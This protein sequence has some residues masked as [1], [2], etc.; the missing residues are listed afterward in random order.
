MRE[1]QREDAQKRAGGPH[2]TGCWSGDLGTGIPGC[3][4]YRE[5]CK[6]DKHFL[7][8]HLPWNSNQDADFHK[9]PY[10]EGHQL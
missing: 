10:R 3:T 6:T 4:L 1:Q 5:H 2:P 7:I 8:C 9:E